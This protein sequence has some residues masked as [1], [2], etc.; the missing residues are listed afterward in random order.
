MSGLNGHTWTVRITYWR[1]S[2]TYTG[3]LRTEVM[4]AEQVITDIR[5]CFA[6]SKMITLQDSRGGTIGLVRDNIQ[7]IDVYPIMTEDPPQ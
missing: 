2:R 5:N 7:S 3:T 4:D 1:D 6:R